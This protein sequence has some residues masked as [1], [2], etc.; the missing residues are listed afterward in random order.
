[1]HSG[2]QL[3][4]LASHGVNEAHAQLRIK[5]LICAEVCRAVQAAY[6]KNLTALV[7]T[8]SLAR[9]EATIFQNGVTLIVQGDVDFFLVST[10]PDTRRDENLRAQTAAKIEESLCSQGIHVHIGINQVFPSYLSS[11]PKFIATF[12]LRECGQVLLGNPNILK[13]I[14]E[15]SSIDISREDAWRM[16]CNRMIELLEVLPPAGQNTALDESSLQYAT[17]KL[18]LDLATSYLVFANLYEPT[19]RAREARMR[20]IVRNPVSLA[21]TT[22]F[23]LGEF[24]GRLSACTRWKLNEAAD[25]PAFALP[26]WREAIRDALALWRWELL[27]LTGGTEP[28]SDEEL[29]R[30]WSQKL[31]TKERLR[32]WLSVARR[33]SLAECVRNAPRW[34]RLG[35]IASARYFIYKASNALLSARLKSEDEATASVAP[36]HSLDTIMGFLPVADLKLDSSD[37]WR[38]ASQ[39]VVLNYK[40]FLT[41]TLA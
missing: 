17:A 38:R 8:G 34:A 9:N 10:K 4:S 36:K 24:S 19:Y 37:E 20:A 11:L 35:S 28:V 21:P 23:N 40:K 29:W 25:D 31:S 2:S 5:E 33:S 32:G 12:E 16:L 41:G 1:M 7:L 27:Q 14:P 22:P 15:F 39:T 13:L 6:P 3:A 30:T 18:T 26:T